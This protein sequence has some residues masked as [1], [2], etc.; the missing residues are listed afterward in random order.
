MTRFLA[1]ENVPRES[2]R[3]LREH[4]H[5]IAE[6]REI[7]PSAS[8][9]I[10]LARARNEHR[11]L[12]TFDRDYGELIFI[13]GMVPPPGVIYFRLS[14]VPPIELAIRVLSLLN[15]PDL[16]LDATFVIVD[17]ERTRMRPLPSPGY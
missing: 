17:A 3:L 16:A 7:D 5:D 9:A 4:G 14:P 10:V 13:R 15:D 1:N 11:V 6:I 12:L 8:D 2:V